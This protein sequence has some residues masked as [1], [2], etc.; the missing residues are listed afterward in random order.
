MVTIYIN[1]SK[2]N[3]IFADRLKDLRKEQNLSLKQ[4]AKLIGVSDVAIGRW[5]KKLQIPNIVILDLIAR[6]FKVSPNY[7]LGYED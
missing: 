2:V 5:E 6:Y 7:L 3:E 4:L 1:M